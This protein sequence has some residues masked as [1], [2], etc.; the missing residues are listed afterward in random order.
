[1]REKC[2]DK[3]R[4]EHIVEAIDDAM[5]FSDGISVEDLDDD[6]I[7]FYAITK[8]IEIIGE[9]VYMLSSEFKD[10]HPETEWGPIESMRHFLVHEYFQVSKGKIWNVLKND[11][12]PLREQIAD[13]LK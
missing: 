3:E 7:R 10:T 13:Y 4:L 5:A 11:L 1:M 8:C 2:R 9:A 6:K 12:L